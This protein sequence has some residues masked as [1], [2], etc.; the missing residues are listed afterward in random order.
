MKS[1]ADMTRPFLWAHRGVSARA[2][3]NTMAAFSAAAETGADG[4]E[5][6]VHLARDGVPVVIHDETLE[7]TTDGCGP[8]ALRSSQQ[9]G[10]LD[11]GSWFAE[12]FTGV[13][14]PTL[15]AVLDAFA[16]RLKLNL[17]LKEPQAG[18][19]TL[20]IIRQYPSAEIVISSFN[21]ALLRQLRAVDS[22]LPLALLYESGNWRHAIALAKELSACAF[23][24][25]AASV[26]RRMIAA[27]RQA[28]M[29]VHAW[30]VDQIPEARSLARAGVSGFFSNDPAFFLEAFLQVKVLP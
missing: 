20:D 27:A 1:I 8:V 3:E 17:E 10:K 30:T 28:G 22:G 13:P 24:T 25:S 26:N 19:T 7:R 15:S 14:V 16:S 6:D 18:V 9:L 5:L 21:Y 23:H 11:A 12:E 2:P 29:H 4:I